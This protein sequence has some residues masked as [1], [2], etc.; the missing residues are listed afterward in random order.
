V[1]ALR[2]VNLITEKN[3]IIHHPQNG[4]GIKA[5]KNK[6]NVQDAISKSLKINYKPFKSHHY[7]NA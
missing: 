5:S 7:E 3:E 6:E 4:S 2:E 1:K